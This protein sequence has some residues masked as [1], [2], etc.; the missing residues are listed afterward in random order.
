MSDEATATA[1]A[2]QAKMGGLYDETEEFAWHYDPAQKPARL[3]IYP[4]RL[5]SNFQS[6]ITD[7]LVEADSNNNLFIEL[8]G[9]KN[10]LNAQLMGYE[11]DEYLTDEEIEEKKKIVTRL[12]ERKER[13]A[14]IEGKPRTAKEV[15]ADFFC[16]IIKSH[17]LADPNGAPIPVT[18]EG[19]CSIVNDK[20]EKLYE[21]LTRFLLS[22][23]G[24]RKKR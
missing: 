5:Q 4:Y 13:L 2:P 6:H 8:S 20:F 14:E 10:R 18:R 7:Q 22:E 21:D 3:I 16:L 24:K 11:D 12:A 23:R 19:F 1:E 15:M 17:N 9:K